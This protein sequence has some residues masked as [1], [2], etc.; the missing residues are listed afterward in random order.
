MKQGDFTQLA[1]Q[2]YNRPGYSLS[3]LKM[4]AHLAG[5]T[6]ATNFQVADVGAGTGKLTENLAELGF[7]GKAVE[8]N[9]AMRAEGQKLFTSNTSFT[10]HK[11]TAEETGLESNTYNWVLMG[12]SFHWTDPKISLKEFRRILKPGGFFTA[13]WNPRDLER[14]ELQ[15]EID[16]EIHKMVPGLNRV[17]SGA[18][19]YTTDIEKVLAADGYFKD[20]IFIEAPHEVV[21]SK[22][23]YMGAWRSVNDIRAQA[24]EEGF[25][26]VLKMIEQKIEKQ[27]EIVM[28]YKTRAWTAQ[29]K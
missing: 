19:K 24:G 22:D 29:A 26:N 27:K 23:R 28:P 7:K 12:S 11:G 25:Q 9:D 10:W 18:K 5:A 8:P 13:I 15:M 14:N 20:V 17:S 6:T 21:M 2:Y 16:A 1:S 3:A 4:L